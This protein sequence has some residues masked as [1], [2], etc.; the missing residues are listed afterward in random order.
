MVKKAKDILTT[1]DVAK[2]CHVT[3]RTVIKWYEQ[4]RLDGYRLPGSRDR[5]FTRP[6]VE[7]FIR[8]NDLP[9]V[10]L[11]SEGEEGVRVLVVDDDEAIRNLV[12]RTVAELPGFEVRTA[13]TGWEA[14]LQ[15]ASYEP[16]VL[17]LDYRL[18]DTTG[19]EVLKTIRS[20][21]KISQPVIIVMS[22]YLEEEKVQELLTSGADGFL[23][24]PFDLAELR[25]LALQHAGALA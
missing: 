12:Q 15:T 23:P 13:A 11:G 19:G 4:G 10:F 16:H 22:A 20:H 14:G 7:S 1:G 21:D 6:A 5:R 18:G 3:I 25:G 24:K 17:F 2:L 9:D 8:E